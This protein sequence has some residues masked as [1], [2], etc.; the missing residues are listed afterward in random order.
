MSEPIPEQELPPFI[1]R[2]GL[3]NWNRYAAVNEEFV[4]MHMDDD[5]GQA[6]GFPGAIGMGNLQIAYIHNF[7][8]DWIGDEG[9]IA[10]ASCEFRAPNLK[11]TV[12][13]V[14]G[15][16][17]NIEESA[18]ARLTHV[19]F[20]VTGSHGPNE[21]AVVLARGSAAVEHS[22]QN[23]AQRHLSKSPSPLTREGQDR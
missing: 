3:A 2:T 23:A 13:T 1:R 17:T 9:R 5:A 20:I 16:V 4:A 12:V 6:F 18:D 21:P 19:T 7:L 8:R 10:K 15:A 22:R 11:D 14:R